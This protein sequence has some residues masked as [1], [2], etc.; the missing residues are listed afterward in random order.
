MHAADNYICKHVKSI[1]KRKLKK[2]VK[3][4]ADD[5][6]KNVANRE[7]AYYEQFPPFCNCILETCLLKMHRIGILFGRGSN[8]YNNKS[9][10]DDFEI[11]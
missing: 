4:A 8:V 11:T 7:I 2:R 10:A 1:K 3:S 5:F 9:A 6:E